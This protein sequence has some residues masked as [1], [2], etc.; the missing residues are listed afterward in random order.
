MPIAVTKH[1]EV[2]KKSSKNKELTP[3]QKKL[4]AGP[5]MTKKQ[6]KEYEKL[7]PWLKNYKD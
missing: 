3:L 4:L 6:I 1:K 5:T 7:Y 2:K